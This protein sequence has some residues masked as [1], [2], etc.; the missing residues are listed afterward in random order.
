M[1]FCFLA[2]YDIILAD[3]E[4]VAPPLVGAGFY[5]SDAL[6]HYNLVTPCTGGRELTG[7][8]AFAGASLRGSGEADS[9]L[10]APPACAAG[11]PLSRA[12]PRLGRF[13]SSFFL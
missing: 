4:F 12:P 5:L 11:A 13:S 6:S 2:D 7:F 3:Y 1:S 8:F 10:L 9:A